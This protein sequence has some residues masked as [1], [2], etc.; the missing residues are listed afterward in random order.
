MGLWGCREQEW[1]CG[2]VESKSGAVGLC[3]ARVDCGAVR[4]VA[5]VWDKKP[6]M[7][8]PPAGTQLEPPVLTDLDRPIVSAAGG[9]RGLHVRAVGGADQIVRGLY[10][11]PL[12]RYNRYKPL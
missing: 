1:G 2:A 11:K 3:R 10:T 4:T 8:A 12:N 5:L 6:V 7:H 9:C